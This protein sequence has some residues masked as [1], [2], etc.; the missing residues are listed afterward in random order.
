VVWRIRDRATFEAL[1][2]SR[3]R[4]RRGAVTVTFSS[5]GV[6]PRV[7]YAVGKK[8]GGSVERNRLRRRLRAAVAEAESGVAPGA[9]LVA[10]G[11]AAGELGFEELKRTVAA[12]M[13]AAS[14]RPHGERD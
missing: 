5:G 7:A 11:P 9:Y 6:R 1:R 2:R 4:G 12:A 14:E 3:L 8:V 13:T 10:A